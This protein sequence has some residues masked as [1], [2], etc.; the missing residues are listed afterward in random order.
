[1]I[2]LLRF[3]SWGWRTIFSMSNSKVPLK[4]AKHIAREAGSY[5]NY[6]FHISSCF[7]CSPSENIRKVKMEWTEKASISIECTCF[8]R[9][10]TFFVESARPDPRFDVVEAESILIEYQFIK[11][12][13]IQVFYVFILGNFVCGEWRDENEYVIGWLEEKVH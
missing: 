3:G 2:N 11:F 5:L 13:C 9:N 4:E 10:T 7:L 1:M 8:L 6:N 12:W